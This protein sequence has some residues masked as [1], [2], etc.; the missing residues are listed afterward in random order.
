MTTAPPLPVVALERLRSA[1]LR[2]LTPVLRVPI[3][4]RAF[5]AQ[6][7]RVPLF[8]TAHAAVAFPVALLAPSLSLVLAPLVLGVP[9]VASD[10]RHL[11]ARRGLPRG[12]VRALAA[13]AVALFATRVVA[14]THRFTDGSVI[15]AEHALATACLLA[16][17]VVGARAGGWRRSAWVSL[18]AAFVVGALSLVE[19]RALRAALVYGHNLI[20]IAIWLLLFRRGGRWSLLPVTAILLGATLLGS[21]ALLAVT[22]R[23][24]MLSA[25]GLH[26][27]AA[28][29]MLAP[30]ASDAGGMSLT[31]MFAF[32]QAVH[33]AI[34]LIA[35]PQDDGR[36]RGRPSISMTWRS[37][38]HDLSP[39]GLRVTVA[40]V[41]LVAVAGI[42]TP[43]R[44][45]A[46][47]LSLVTFHA[48]LELALLLF[49]VARDGFARVPDSSA[50]PRVPHPTHAVEAAP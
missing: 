37:L 25:F 28:A 13:F 35:I 7:S 16:G 43:L 14:E 29:D 48:W 9:H 27:G 10:V 2:A 1:S 32:L 34:W 36:P 26:L 20:A 50:A 12:W 22:L 47:F 30:G 15:R 44:T 3:V 17:A 23:H 39:V 5:T 4:R 42:A 11:V 18:A 41:A 33:Y 49:F 45:R 46:V 21:G 19:P 6:A 31:T 8:L 38:A 40:L 24:G